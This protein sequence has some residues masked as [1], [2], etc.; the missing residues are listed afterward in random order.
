MYKCHVFLHPRYMPKSHRGNMATPRVFI[1]STCYDLKHIRESLKYFISN[2]GY[3]P[4]LSEDGDVFYSPS[5]HTQDSCLEEVL[6]CQLFVLIIG[7]RHGGKHKDTDKS[8]TNEEYISA[9]GNGIPVFTLVES[10]T[11]ADH[12]LYTSNKNNPEIDRDKIT[13]PASDSIQIFHFLDEVRKHSINNA[14]QSFK[15]FSDIESYLKKQW[16]GMMFELL[17]KSKNDTQ[18]QITRKLL[19]DL[20]LASRKTEELIKFL[21]NS[22][23][24]DN[25][26]SVINNADLF[27]KAQE[28]P[29]LIL[30][31]WEIDSFDYIPLEN[32]NTV[33]TQQ[34][35]YDF[36]QEAFG[37]HVICIKSDESYEEI[38]MWAPTKVGG[39]GRSI[40]TITEDGKE[41][42]EKGEKEAFEAFATLSEE[43]R[44]KILQIF[45]NGI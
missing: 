16:A 39:L 35:W 19:S 10:A 34:S 8:I 7:G 12:H 42:H 33:S 30:E 43:G 4:V 1:S 26:E 20:S 3:E 29:S 23:D 2:I 38:V 37:F 9:I 13:Y 21:V 44:S 41:Y 45:I 18:S 25:A 31:Q 11:Y 17:Q 36:L 14:I 24:K 22:V 5:S 6:T 32:I 28:F 27:A 15:N 40:A